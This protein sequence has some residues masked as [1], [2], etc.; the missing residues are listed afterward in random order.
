MRLLIL[1]FTLSIITFSS[2]VYGLSFTVP[3]VKHDKCV[4]FD[5]PHVKVLQGILNKCDT[6][7]NNILGINAS[8]DNGPD[9]ILSGYSVYQNHTIYDERFILTN[10]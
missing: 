10:Q 5:S 3:A 6:L 2:N 7:A 1:L 8:S 4:A 9:W